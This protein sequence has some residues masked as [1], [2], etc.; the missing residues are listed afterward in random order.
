MTKFN[1]WFSKIKKFYMCIFSVWLNPV[2]SC[3]SIV[4]RVCLSAQEIYSKNTGQNFE[5]R[6]WQEGFT[7]TSSSYFLYFLLKPAIFHLMFFAV[8]VWVAKLSSSLTF[9]SKASNICCFWLMISV[10]QSSKYLRRRVTDS[11]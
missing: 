9:L 3:S 7:S 4:L 10:C 1:Y 2:F 8:A 6:S 11:K 5:K